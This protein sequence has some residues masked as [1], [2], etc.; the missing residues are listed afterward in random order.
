VLCKTLYAE[1]QR[2]EEEDGREISA[3]KH[4]SKNTIYEKSLH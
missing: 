2:G 3:K 1:G 4:I